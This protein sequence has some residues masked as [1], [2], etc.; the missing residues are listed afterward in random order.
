MQCCVNQK[1]F[2]DLFCIRKWYHRIKHNDIIVE[3]EVGVEAMRL[4]NAPC[5][6]VV[7]GNNAND[8]RNGPC[9]VRLTIA[10]EYLVFLQVSSF[11]RFERD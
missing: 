2:L 1:L 11:R 4:M 8:D 3:V 9:V 5:E 6:E 7:Q 10:L